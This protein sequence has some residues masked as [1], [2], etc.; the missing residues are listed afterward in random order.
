MFF[1]DSVL[2]LPQGGEVKDKAYGQ[3]Q[4]SNYILSVN[5][6]FNALLF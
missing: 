3:A 6:M 1:F 4:Y 2:N 5:I